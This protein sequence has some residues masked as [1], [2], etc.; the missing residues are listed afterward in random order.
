MRGAIIQE[1]IL[2]K[3]LAAACELSVGYVRQFVR[4]GFLTVKKEKRSTLAVGG[5]VPLSKEQWR[6]EIMEAVPE[7]RHHMVGFSDCGQ[8]E[9]PSAP[10]SA[11][12][13]TAETWIAS[14]SRNPWSGEYSMPEISL[15]DRIKLRQ[16]AERL[17]RSDLEFDRSWD[18]Y[19]EISSASEA[20]LLGCL[21]EAHRLG[22]S[23]A[24]KLEKERE[25][26]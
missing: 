25:A 8:M 22:R 13:S 23:A 15:Q 17:V 11:A 3:D 6:S 20:V 1:P 26:A 7:G 19:V 16:M 5:Y 4:D 21:E 18:G 9:I 24:Q 14:M 12:S 10:T 2:L